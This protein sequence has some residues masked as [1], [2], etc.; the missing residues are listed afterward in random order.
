[1]SDQKTTESGES[2]PQR[3]RGVRNELRR[4]FEQAVFTDRI[5]RG[6]TG[7]PLCAL[8]S[9]SEPVQCGRCLFCYIRSRERAIAA[10]RDVYDKDPAPE[11]MAPSSK[12]ASRRLALREALDEVAKSR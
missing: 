10:A 12:A 8:S 6:P 3:R 4:D 9:G 7:K 1:M 2:V 5:K 11:V